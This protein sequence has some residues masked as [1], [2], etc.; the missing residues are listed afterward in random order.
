MIITVQGNTWIVGAP[1]EMLSRVNIKRNHL[2][3][4][5]ENQQSHKFHMI[6]I[7]KSKA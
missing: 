4:M 5:K 3:D 6:E 1:S 2:F 7:T